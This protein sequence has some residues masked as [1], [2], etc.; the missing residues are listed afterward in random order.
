MV[1]DDKF[2]NEVIYSLFRN[3]KHILNVNR[4][5]LDSLFRTVDMITTKLVYV[6]NNYSLK[7]IIANKT[8]HA[9]IIHDIIVNGLCIK[10]RSLVVDAR[11]IK[12]ETDPPI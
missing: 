5:Y 12:R 8:L 10:T 3:V 11:N 7:P 9:D 6:E 2:L 1:G 4:T